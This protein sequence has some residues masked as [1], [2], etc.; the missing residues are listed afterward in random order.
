MAIQL[1]KQAYEKIIRH[2]VF[3]EENKNDIMDTLLHNGTFS[4]KLTSHS[5]I[6]SYIKRIEAVLTNITLVEQEMFSEDYNSLPFIIIG[7]SF[8]LIDKSK[9]RHFC[10]LTSDIYGKTAGAVNNIY[11]FSESGV[12]ILMKEKN[13]SCILDLGGGFGEYVINSITVS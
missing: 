6:K 4:S 5:F 7:S 11:A 2:L 12:E 8:T 10:C 13:A 9:T 3:I 1:K